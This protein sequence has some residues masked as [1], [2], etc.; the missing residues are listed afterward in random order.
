ML[1]TGKI[2]NK[3]LAEWFG[4]SAN[5][6]NKAK[7]KFLSRLSDFADF[8]LEGK[9]IIIDKVYIDTYEK[10]VGSKSYNMIKN[11]VDEVWNK[12]GLDS[13]RRVSNQIGVELADQ[14]TIGDNT[15]YNYVRRSRNEL[16]GV[17]FGAEG[18]LGSCCYIWCKKGDDGMLMPFT[19]EE[20]RIK[21]DL[22]KKYFGKA[23]EK[24]VIVEAMV[25]AGEIRKEDAWDVLRSLTNMQGGNFTTFL[26]ELQEKLNCQIIRGTKIERR[27]AE[28][29]GSA[30]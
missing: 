16:Y 21:E 17:P 10:G 24:Q 18:S 27:E 3:D 22:M 30:F 13:C 29:I 23:S 2:S 4:V 25:M 12:N 28:K 26:G 20:E 15:R 1:E 11:K 5:T 19:E 9:K 6:F 14:L 7:D 8:H